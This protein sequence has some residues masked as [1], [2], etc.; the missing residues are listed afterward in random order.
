MSTSVQS[1]PPFASTSTTRLL[2]LY[3]DVSRQ[4]HSNPTSYH[5]N[6][7]WWHH[8]LESLVSSGTQRPAGGLVLHADS[9]LMDCLKIE[10]VGKP[11]GLGAVIVRD[12][13]CW[14]IQTD[15]FGPSKNELC[16]SNVLVPLPTFLGSKQSIYDPGWLP[17]RIAAY[18]VGKPL[19]WTL[20]Q[21]GIVGEDGLLTPR[22]RGNEEWWG[23]YVFLPL[24]ERAADALI[25]KQQSRA[26]SVADHLYDLPSFRK[27]FGSALS[28]DVLSSE[29]ASILLKFLERD[30]HIIVVEQQVQTNRQY[31]TKI[32]DRSVKVIKFVDRSASAEVQQIS[33]VDQGILELKTAVLNMHTQ[34]ESLHDKMD[35]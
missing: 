17:A 9:S 23:D 26:T 18:I 7:N 5:A 15:S 20:E 10:G 21:L 16:A 2:A 11:L 22:A 27:E 33:A 19:W 24:L 3:S 6:V 31:H 13:H 1:L 8:A 35:E 32:T 28:Q 34:I 12:S 29:G 30:R 14:G 25:T 4:K